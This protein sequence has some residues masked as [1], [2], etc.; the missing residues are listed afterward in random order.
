M[1]NLTMKLVF[2]WMGCVHVQRVGGRPKSH[3]Q[4][5][6][7]VQLLTEVIGN[8]DSESGEQRA[9]EDSRAG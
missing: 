6:K 1:L 7:N 4:D 9:E 8:D 3:T 5:D 2:F